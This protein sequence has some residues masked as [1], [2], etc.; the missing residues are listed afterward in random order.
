M[1]EESK[2]SFEEMQNEESIADIFKE[3]VE[4]VS[5]FT[6]NYVRRKEQN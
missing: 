5:K 4:E 1:K 3:K 2:E 6:H